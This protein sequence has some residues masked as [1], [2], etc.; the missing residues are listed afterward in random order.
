MVSFD[1]SEHLSFI[2]SCVLI[3]GLNAC[4][5]GFPLESAFLS[6]ESKHIPKFLLYLTEDITF[7]VEILA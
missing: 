1:V 2:R 5:T 7:Y 6:N 3:F 4:A